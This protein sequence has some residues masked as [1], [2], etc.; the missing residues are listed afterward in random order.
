MYLFSCT[1][2]NHA[3][4]YYL[5]ICLLCTYVLLSYFKIFH[6]ISADRLIILYAYN[7]MSNS[8]FKIEFDIQS[9]PRQRHIWLLWTQTSNQTPSQDFQLS[10]SNDLLKYY[11]IIS[12]Q[13]VVEIKCQSRINLVFF[14]FHDIVWETS[15][16]FN[17]VIWVNLVWISTGWRE[18]IL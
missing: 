8:F 9:V 2:E 15:V 6:N 14:C 16:T 5:R 3:S 12:K 18:Y 13:R 11:P 10:S 1:F 7:C 17:W 4:T